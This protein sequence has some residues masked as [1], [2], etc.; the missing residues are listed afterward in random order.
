MQV[1]QSKTVEPENGSGV[2]SFD[3]ISSTL[4][5]NDKTSTVEYQASER[6]MLLTTPE[7]RKLAASFDEQGRPLHS[8][9]VDSGIWPVEQAYDEFG[10]LQE[11]AQGTGSERRVS[12]LHY[13]DQGFVDSMT[14]A[15]NRTVNFVRDDAGRV[16]YPPQPSSSRAAE[17][18]TGTNPIS[19]L[20]LERSW[21]RKRLLET[22]K[23][24]EKLSARSASMALLT[25][26]AQS[27]RLSQN[28]W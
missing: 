10:R 25:T 27:R 3:R 26:F 22:A 23:R 5:I 2:F 16:I 6:S 15:L 21:M 9:L 7:G 17:S 19:S 4:T 1:E 28:A 18:S 8:E 20:A 14:D 12:S 11:I 13:D 24:T